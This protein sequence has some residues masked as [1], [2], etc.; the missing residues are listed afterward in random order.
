MEIKFDTGPLALEENNYTTKFACT[1]YDLNNWPNNPLNNFNF[2]KCFFGATNIV[3]YNYNKAKWVYS[4]YRIAFDGTS[5]WKFGDD[6]AKNVEIFGVD[7][8]SSSHNNNYKNNFLVL[9]EGLNYGINGSFGSSERKYSINFS[10]TTTKF[11]L[12]LHYNHDNSYSLVNG[13]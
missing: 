6:Y 1:V 11:C 9:G 13:K 3:Q 2:K 5:T 12:I 10:K 4:G 7:N 8:S